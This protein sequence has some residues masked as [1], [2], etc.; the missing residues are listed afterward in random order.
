MN[1]HSLDS[2][3]TRGLPGGSYVLGYSG[4][5]ACSDN[6]SGK[7][8][9]GLSVWASG[10]VALSHGIR[11][12]LSRLRHSGQVAL[13]QPSR[14][15]FSRSIT[16]DAWHSPKVVPKGLSLSGL[17]DIRHISKRVFRLDLRDAWHSPKLSPKGFSKEVSKGWLPGWLSG[18]VACSEGWSEGGFEK[19]LSACF[20]KAPKEVSR[21]GFGNTWHSPKGSEGGLPGWHVPKGFSK[22]V[23]RDGF[24]RWIR[25]RRLGF[26][27]LDRTGAS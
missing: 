6:L 19:G 21:S 15:H 22:G 20:G 12:G 1:L 9:V 25:D 23:F 13:S 3:C 2:R 27:R 16:R 4:H 24:R 14:E 11:G 7:L 17:R 5:V 18:H 8:P 26:H 10:R